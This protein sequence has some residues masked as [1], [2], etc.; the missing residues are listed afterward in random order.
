MGENYR[1]WSVDISSFPEK[2]FI[3]DQLKFLLGFAILAP[4]G[5][6]SQP[7]KFSIKDNK[8]SI[9]VSTERSLKES[10]PEGKQLCI[11]IGCALENFLIASDF[12]GFDV[13]VDYFP[14]PAIENLFI[15]A[16]LVRTRITKNN[17]SHLIFSIPKRLTERNKYSDRMPSEDFLESVRSFSGVE[18]ETVF[19]VDRETKN[20]LAEFA[21]TAQIEAMDSPSFRQELSH[22]MKSNLTKEK[23]GMP[24]FVLGLPLPI[25]F[26][27]PYFMRLTNLSR[28]TKNKDEDLL[29]KYTPALLVITTFRDDRI[30]WIQIGQIFEK[31]WLKAVANGLCCAPWAAPVQVGDYHKKTQQL[32]HLK[33]VPR[34]FS[35]IGYCTTK[36]KHSPRFK[37]EEVVV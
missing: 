18:F 17:E 29:K 1:P 30:G 2:G 21:V 7:W 31:I 32:L 19:V 22:Y 13:T 33:Y 9:F 28:K 23:V 10:D 36:G 4:S 8:V 3:L 34:I 27:A 5:H 37:L 14:D 15:E 12:Y 24:G 25:S 26:V 16:R 20:K 35:R 6:N 11:G